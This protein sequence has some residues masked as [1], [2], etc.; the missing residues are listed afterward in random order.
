[1]IVLPT[2]QAYTISVDVGPEC[3]C[4]RCNEPILA[5]LPIRFWDPSG[6]Y[7]WRY[8]PA[9]LDVKVIEEPEEVEPF[10]PDGAEVLE[11]R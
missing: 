6:R 2:D 5:G 4:S 7:E 8:H 9:C 1:M 11:E 10:G 3:I